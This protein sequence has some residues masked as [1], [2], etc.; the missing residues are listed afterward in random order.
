MT[1]DRETVVKAVAACSEF[2]CGECSYQYLYSRDYPLKCICT[3][4]GDINKMLKEEL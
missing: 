3:L 2:C 1:M 4:M